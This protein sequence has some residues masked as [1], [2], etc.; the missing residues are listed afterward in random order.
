MTSLLELPDLVHRMSIDEYHRAGETGVLS[1]NVE[2]LRGIVVNKMPKSPLHELVCQKLDELLKSLTPKE[3]M[4]RIERPL[5]L[6]DS[7]PEPDLSVVRGRPDDWPGG[8]P[9]TA[10][11]VIEVALSSIPIDEEKADIYADAAIAEY[12]M[13]MP[14]TRS[15]VVYREPTK[16]GY[17]SRQVLTEDDQVTCA[18]I[19]TIRFV[20]KEI[21]PVRPAHP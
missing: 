3:F 1:T 4:V 19:P 8:H 13:V 12:W 17:V 14:E 15:L 21:L 9:S 11:L 2:L 18:S 20:L 6:R 7:E 10:H 5:T 16:E